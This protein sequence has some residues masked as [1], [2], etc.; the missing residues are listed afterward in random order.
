ML[1][2]ERRFVQLVVQQLHFN[3]VFHDYYHAT[4]QRQMAASH[5]FGAQGGVSP[6]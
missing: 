2:S 4:A 5:A 6:R 3:T 1:L